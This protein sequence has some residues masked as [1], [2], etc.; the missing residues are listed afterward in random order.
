MDDDKLV[1]VTTMDK[2]TKYEHP[3]KE[4]TKYEFHEYSNRPVLYIRSISGDTWITRIET[5]GSPTTMKANTSGF[6]RS[7]EDGKRLM[8]AFAK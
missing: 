3:S 2:L 5:N 6:D 7:L 4:I 1:E 8:D